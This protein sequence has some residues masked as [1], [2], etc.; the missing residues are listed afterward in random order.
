MF[1]SQMMNDNLKITKQ[2]NCKHDSNSSSYNVY[3]LM[4]LSIIYST[5]FNDYNIKPRTQLISL[6]HLYILNTNLNNQY[7]AF[8][9]PYFQN[10]R[11]RSVKEIITWYL[12]CLAILK[13]PRRQT[14]KRRNLSSTMAQRRWLKMAR[15]RWSKFRD[16]DFIY[17]DLFN[18]SY[19]ALRF[20]LS[21]II[22]NWIIIENNYSIKVLFW[23]YY[24][25]RAHAL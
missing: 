18:I 12:Y 9:I 22:Q 7:I 21:I 14:W 13:P 5:N 3:N 6:K 4:S 20:N 23:E 19:P 11:Q 2:I 24:R 10:E 1:F 17:Q 15:M 16:I 8:N 25:C